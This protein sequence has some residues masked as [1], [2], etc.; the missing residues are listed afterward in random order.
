MKKH[1][2]I[3]VDGTWT[4]E[5]N[6]KDEAIGK[7]ESWIAKGT[8]TPIVEETNDTEGCDLCESTKEGK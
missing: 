6:S 7:L 5:A 8:A 2:H 4:I 3:G 1:F